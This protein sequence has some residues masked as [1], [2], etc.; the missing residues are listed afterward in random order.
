MQEQILLIL[1]TILTLLTAWSWNSFLQSFIKTYYNDNLPTKFIFAIII[2]IITFS[3]I[4]WLIKYV[5]K[6]EK[7]IEKINNI[8]KMKKYFK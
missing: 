5:I 8:K 3:S 1:I 6:Y 2:S 4:M 7:R